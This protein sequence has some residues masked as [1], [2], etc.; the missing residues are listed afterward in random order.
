MEELIPFCKARARHWGFRYPK[1]ADEFESEAYLVLVKVFDNLEEGKDPKPYLWSCLERAF[2]DVIRK[3]KLVATRHKVKV[4]FPADLDR[5]YRTRAKQ[6]DWLNYEEVLKALSLTPREELIIN[7]L[8]DGHTYRT[9]A[10]ECQ[11][12]VGTVAKAIG[13][14]RDVYWRQRGKLS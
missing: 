5:I 1:L 11:V 7:M 8:V 10:N 3:D 9:I 6:E 14:I 13:R 12:T 2:V 4:E